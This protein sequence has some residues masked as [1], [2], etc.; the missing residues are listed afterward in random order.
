MLASQSFFVDDCYRRDSIQTWKVTID[1]Q[2][3]N[4]SGELGPKKA[5]YAETIQFVYRNGRLD[6]LGNITIKRFYPFPF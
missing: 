3:V 5:D 1:A 6:P 2:M 4:P